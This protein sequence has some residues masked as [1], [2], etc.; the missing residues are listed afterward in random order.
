M[1]EK[2]AII[3]ERRGGGGGGM[4]FSLPKVFF[5]IGCNYLILT[6]FQ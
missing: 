3:L 4:S 1:L 5:E 6:N 2:G